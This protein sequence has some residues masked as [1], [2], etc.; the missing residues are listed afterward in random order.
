MNFDYL[1][2]RLAG[3]LRKMLIR[4]SYDVEFG[5][6]VYVS[7]G[8]HIRTF[9]GGRI[10]IGGNCDIHAGTLI[11]ARRG[12][13]T[14]GSNAVI[15]RGSNIVSSERIEIGDD[16][17]IAEG[18]LIRDSNH[19]R[20][21]KPY[22]LAGMIAQPVHIG[23]NVWIGSKASILAGVSLPDDT[24]VGAGAVVTRSPA[25]AGLLLGVP[26]RIATER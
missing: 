18:V 13:L 7:G 6:N 21:S 9:D 23:A 24:V 14:I 11:E 4:I 8:A 19:S 22:R 16:A 25:V 20:A 5:P 10:R 15:N 26:A 3:A 17:L 2:R 12:L 1:L